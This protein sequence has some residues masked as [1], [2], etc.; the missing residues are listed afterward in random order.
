VPEPGLAIAEM[1][2]T[3]RGGGTVA[4]YVWG[5]AGEIQ[6]LRRFWDVA[7]SLDARAGALD[8]GRRFPLCRPPA[9]EALFRAAGLSRVES[10]AI[11]VPTR[12]RDFADYWT[13]FLGGQGPAPSYVASLSESQREHLRDRLRSEL[14]VA[15]DGSVELS[16]RAWAVRGTLG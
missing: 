8:E 7:V 13:P 10:R 5:Y 2:R 11:D 14:P 3:V 16:A 9:L 12:F 1:A 6:L 4:V 15:S